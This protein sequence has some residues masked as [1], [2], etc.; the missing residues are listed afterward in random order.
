MKKGAPWPSG[1]REGGSEAE[2]VGE[3][4][5]MVV[6]GEMRLSREPMTFGGLGDEVVGGPK[7][8]MWTAP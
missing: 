1:R 3:E 6:G 4:E 8:D 2:R 7:E 5:G